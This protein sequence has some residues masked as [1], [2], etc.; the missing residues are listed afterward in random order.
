MGELTVLHG[1]GMNPDEA[2]WAHM[3]YAADDALMIR[4][5]QQQVIDDLSSIRAFLSRRR[6]AACRAVSRGVGVDWLSSR[7]AFAAAFAA[8]TMAQSESFGE[9]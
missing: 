1:D 6:R 2:A 9:P 3:A 7:S 4:G 5:L 8:P